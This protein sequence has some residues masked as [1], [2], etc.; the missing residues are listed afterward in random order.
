MR[1]TNGSHSRGS[2]RAVLLDRTIG[3]DRTLV[4]EAL[5]S[6]RITIARPGGILYLG[7]S[8]SGSFA[9]YLSS[10][11]RKALATFHLASSA[12]ISRISPARLSVAQDV[13]APPGRPATGPTQ[14]TGDSRFISSPDMETKT[15]SGPPLREIEI[16]TSPYIGGVNSVTLMWVR[17]SQKGWDRV[18]CY[19]GDVRVNRVRD[20]L[21]GIRAY[22]VES[23]YA[24]ITWFTLYVWTF[25][26]D[27]L[28]LGKHFF[29]EKE[30]FPDL[31]DPEAIAA[32]KHRSRTLLAAVLG[33]TSV[34]VLI[35]ASPSLASSFIDVVDSKNFLDTRIYGSF[36]S[37]SYTKN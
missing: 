20:T 13:D 33:A 31:P 29:T 26:F 18:T 4:Q 14:L 25:P 34:A 21:P 17:L 12:L 15:T 7:Y 22:G 28:G 11:A 2:R 9:P 30:F 37:E 10:W 3:T 24:L 1:E 6:G 8:S 5:A 19:T 27:P 32:Q 23:I 35:I 36:T 16:L